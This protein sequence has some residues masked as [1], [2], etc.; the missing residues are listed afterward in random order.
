M[1][2]DE[3]AMTAALKR[4]RARV[5]ICCESG[6]DDTDT[7]RSAAAHAAVASTHTALKAIAV[8]RYRRGRHPSP[9]FRKILGFSKNSISFCGFAGSHGLESS[10]YLRGSPRLPQQR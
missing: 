4:S 7:V 3:P 9:P 5:A 10:T 2:S 6:E 1:P 8:P